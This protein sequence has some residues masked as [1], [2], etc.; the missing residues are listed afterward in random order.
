MICKISFTARSTS[1]LGPRTRMT[2]SVDGLPAL[3]PTFIDNDLSSPMILW[4][5]AFNVNKMVRLEETHAFK[6]VPPLPRTASCHF[7]STVRISLLTSP[8]SL[9][10]FSISFDTSSRCF[11]LSAAE[12]CAER[13]SYTSKMEDCSSDSLG[14]RTRTL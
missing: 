2:S 1:L 12:G 8:Q 14:K 5:I 11:F 10:I 3:A 7:L 13:G 9:T 4:G 6:V